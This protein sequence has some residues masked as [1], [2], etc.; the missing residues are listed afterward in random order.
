MLVVANTFETEYDVRRRYRRTVRKLRI[1]QM[2]RIGATVIGLFPAF[3]KSRFKRTSRGTALQQACIKLTIG[4]DVA[5]RCR[6]HRV[7]RRRLIWR[8]D[9]DQLSCRSLC[10]CECGNP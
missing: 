7:K 3:G 8:N 10:H 1:A 5:R 6:T 4:L 9:S 2:K